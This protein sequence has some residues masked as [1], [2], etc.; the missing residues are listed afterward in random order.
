MHRCCCSEIRAGYNQVRII[1]IDLSKEVNDGAANG[2]YE[3][4]AIALE[5]IAVLSSASMPVQLHSLGIALAVSYPSLG[6]P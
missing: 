3:P 6:L 1:Y 4:V 5:L 2:R